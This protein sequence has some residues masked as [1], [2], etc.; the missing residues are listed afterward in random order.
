MEEEERIQNKKNVC[1]K[2]EEDNDA[3]KMSHKIINQKKTTLQFD[4]NDSNK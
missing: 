3:N 4:S 2:W 1:T